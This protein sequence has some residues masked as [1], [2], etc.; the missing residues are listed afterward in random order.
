MVPSPQVLWKEHREAFCLA[1]SKGSN[2]SNRMDLHF[3]NNSKTIIL[4]FSFKTIK[5]VYQMSGVITA[6]R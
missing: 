2:C 1:E 5:C 4:Y 3:R 6:I